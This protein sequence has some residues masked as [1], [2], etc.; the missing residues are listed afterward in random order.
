M[1]MPAIAST[2]LSLLGSMAT[3][4]TSGEVSSSGSDFASILALSLPTTEKSSTASVFDAVGLSAGSPLG[5]LASR[6]FDPQSGYALMSTINAREV[7][8]K[9]Q[10]S[11]LSAMEASVSSLRGASQ[12]LAMAGTAQDAAG[13]PAALRDFVA[14]YNDWIDR[15]AG[16]VEQNGLLAGTQAATVTLNELEISLGNPFNGA[17]AGVRGLGDLG[18]SIDPVTRRA[19]ID[20]ARLDS[21]LAAN[22]KGALS[23]VGEFAAN[24]SRSAELLASDGNFLANRLGNLGRAIGWIDDRR[25]ALEQEFGAGMA[26]RPTGKLADALAA[27]RRIATL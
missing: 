19:S 11:E 22:P 12:K 2:L 15:F 17:A 23:A 9:A 1:T 14:Q 5:D 13:I 7:L 4:R 20:A 26:S 8:Y 24:F 10:A 25:S 16:S 18:V 3:T 27:Y 21:V 6:L